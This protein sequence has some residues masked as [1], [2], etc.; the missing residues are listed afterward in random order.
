MAPRSIFWVLVAIV[1]AIALGVNLTIVSLTGNWV[2]GG[3]MVLTGV[4]LIAVSL[5][6][7]LHGAGVR[8]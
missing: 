4:G 7:F 5:F 6:M 3:P 1:A 8:R 2:I